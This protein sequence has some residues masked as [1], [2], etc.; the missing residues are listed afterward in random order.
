[1]TPLSFPSLGVLIPEIYL[2]R[3]DAD[4][5][6]RAVVACDQYTS[7]LDY[8][9]AVEKYVGDQ[10]STYRITFPEVY[11]HQEGSDQRISEIQQHMKEYLEQGILENKGN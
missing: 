8:W 5:N 1:M 2:P 7:Q 4:R 3:K 6:K 11:L 10:P 9:E